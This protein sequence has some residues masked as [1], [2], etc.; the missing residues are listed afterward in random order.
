MVWYGDLSLSVSWTFSILWEFTYV[1]NTLE[2]VCLHLHVKTEGG[3]K[4]TIQS[5]PRK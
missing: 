2:A 3:K 1:F 5:G 4:I